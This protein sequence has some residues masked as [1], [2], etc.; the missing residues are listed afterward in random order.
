MAQ[1]PQSHLARHR[2]EQHDLQKKNMLELSAVFGHAFVKP[3]TMK[4][5]RVSTRDGFR[6]TLNTVLRR[7]RVQGIG[8]M[9]IRQR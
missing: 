3:H 1:I 2:R 5:T 7:M 9:L 8:E 6:K 4:K